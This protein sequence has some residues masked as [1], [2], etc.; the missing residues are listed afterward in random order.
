MTALAQVAEVLKGA[1]KVARQL[2]DSSRQPDMGVDIN[3]PCS[4]LLSTVLA[5]L[6]EVSLAVARE[7]ETREAADRDKRR[8]E[9]PRVSESGSES[10][11]N[12]V[13]AFLDQ[14]ATPDD[15]VLL[16]KP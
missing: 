8:P 15:G 12:P 7:R 11:N 9:Y 5:K 16:I 14:T 6:A 1:E 3:L 13:A 4:R 2:L 10:S